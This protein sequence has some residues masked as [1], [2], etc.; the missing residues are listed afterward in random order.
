MIKTIPGNWRVSFDFSDTEAKKNA[1]KFCFVF[2]G[3]NGL[4]AQNVVTLATATSGI[5]KFFSVID[6]TLR[7]QWSQALF[8]LLQ[9]DLSPNFADTQ[10]SH[11]LRF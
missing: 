4:Y 6:V 7:H 11:F 1:I 10:L 2:G 9:S 5:A 8:S 3:Q